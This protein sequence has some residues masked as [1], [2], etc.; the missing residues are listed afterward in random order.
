MKR[1]FVY[2]TTIMLGLVAGVSLTFLSDKSLNRIQINQWQSDWN[3]GSTQADPYLRAHV[4]RFG[5]LAL[6]KQEA[7]YFI[8][9]EDDAGQTLTE[10]CDYRVFIGPMPADW[11]SVTLYDGQG[12]LGMN[13]HNAHAFDATKA[14]S[15]A[16]EFDISPNTPASGVAWV[17]SKNTGQFGLMLRLYKPSATLLAQPETELSPPK[18]T[19]LECKD[20]KV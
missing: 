2:F 12:Y 15:S 5:L 10:A 19:R 3:I 13:G 9:T 18:I 6:S 4:A 8:A 14:D 16:A 20:V 17:S 7:V 11:W 1:I